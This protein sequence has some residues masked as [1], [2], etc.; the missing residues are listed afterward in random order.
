MKGL[1]GSVVMLI[2]LV[3]GAG[4]LPNTASS[5][6]RQ[7][8]IGCHDR[9]T[10]EGGLDLTALPFDLNDR[11]VRERWVRIHDRI[12]KGEMPPQADDLPKESRASLVKSLQGA[13]YE[14]DL[15][16]IKTHGRG[17]MRRL[18]REEFEQNLRDVLKLPQLDI[19]DMLPE[20]REGHRFNKTSETLYE[21][22]AR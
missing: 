21:I 6:L 11:A 20:D 3:A 13:I 12:E 14:S 2:P 18:N 8:C 9:E 10:S 17:P 5:L 22:E 1:F 15:A 4:E 19:R 16:D 7:A